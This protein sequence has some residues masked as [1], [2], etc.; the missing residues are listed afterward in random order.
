MRSLWLSAALVLFAATTALAQT[1]SRFVV[2]PVVRVD[3]VRVQGGV[4]SVMPVFGAIASM[5]LSKIF[6]VEGEIT[7]A[8]GRELVHSYEGVSETFAPLDSTLQEKERLGVHARWRFGYRPGLGGAVAMTAGGSVSHRADLVFRLGLSFRNYLQSYEYTVLSIPEGIDPSRLAGVS[9]GNGRSSGNPWLT[10][11]TRGGLLM[12]L[13][14]PIRI[15]GRFSLVL[16]V[17]Y[18][19]GGTSLNYTHKEVSV[20]I[21]GGWGF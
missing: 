14:V 8:G 7:Q 9:F 1:A 20:G 18:V 5:R 11:M 21:R 16:D 3:K 2:G 15:A 17:R 19:N 6:G 10:N 13:D 4:S 12:G